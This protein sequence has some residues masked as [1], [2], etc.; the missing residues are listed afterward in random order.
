MSNPT[1]LTLP[2]RLGTPSMVLRDDPRVDPRLPAALAPFELDG[3]AAALP[4]GVDAPLEARLAFGAEA[5]PG[6]EG[7][8]AALMAGV[9]A[10]EG[11]ESSTQEIEGMD[12]NSITLYIHRPAGADE[13]LPG[14]LHIHGGGMAILSAGGPL[15]T[16]WRTQLAATGLVV[17]GVEFRNAAGSL[18]PHPFPAG[19]N[20]CTS[21]LQWMYD[22]KTS[23][24]V[25]KI[26]ISGESGGANLSLAT[27][28]K[29]KQDN[30]LHQI[31]GV[32]AQ[33][34]YISNDYTRKATG[35]PSLTEN[36][37]YFLNCQMMGVLASLY[38]GA[39]S[40]NPLAW[41]YYATVEDLKG[42]PPHTISVN[43][44]DP[45]RDEGLAYYRKLLAAGVRAV[46]RTV[47]GT[48]HAGDV[49]FQRDMPEVAAATKR[50]IHSF[51]ASL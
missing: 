26:V 50:D 15:F 27:T 7:L 8:F 25:S 43:E 40:T 13:A 36:D 37:T 21:A 33:C 49:I 6:F 19:L 39:D 51:A 28:L 14:I 9:P 12:G 3:A 46:G 10:Q 18:G 45:L 16:H 2:G 5:E 47:N 38:D 11:V 24:G 32:Y 17:V 20:D 34:P 42:L 23:L 29:A 30:R 44:L 35:L 4:F 31:D 1:T 41:P 22:N 48:T